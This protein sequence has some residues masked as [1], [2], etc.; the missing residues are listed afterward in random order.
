MLVRF[1]IGVILGFV[2]GALAAK[3]DGKENIPLI[4]SGFVCAGYVLYSG[5][6]GFEF[7]ILGA[8][9]VIIGAVIGLKILDKGDP[10]E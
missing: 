4:V 9:E 10:V 7:L 5:S 2:F 3:S 1:I 6:Y 8:V